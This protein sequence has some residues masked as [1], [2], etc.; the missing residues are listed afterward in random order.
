MLSSL[1]AITFL[2]LAAVI[3]LS[4]SILVGRT[5]DSKPKIDAVTSN[6]FYPVQQEVY[7]EPLSFG[8][9]VDQE[10]AAVLWLHFGRQLDGFYRHAPK[11]DVAIMSVPAEAIDPPAPPPAVV[12]VPAESP[13]V[14]H[15]VGVEYWRAAVANYPWP[16]DQAL[17]VMSCESKGDPNAVSSSGDYGLFQ[18][19]QI[20][21]IFL[22]PYANI[23]KAYALYADYGNWHHWRFSRSC[24]GLS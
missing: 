2:L 1:R 7:I 12:Q 11:N 13:Q 8:S 3:T 19:N 21:G 4:S 6:H 17:A 9:G 15:A 22:D 23:G 20:H 16:V 14:Y 24:H 18:L 10:R 5:L